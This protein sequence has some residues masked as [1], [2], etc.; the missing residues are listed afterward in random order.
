VTVTCA[1][2]LADWPEDGPVHYAH[3]D[4][5]CDDPDACNQRA[6]GLLEDTDAL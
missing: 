1:H 3:G 4:W 6:A 2:C 5:W